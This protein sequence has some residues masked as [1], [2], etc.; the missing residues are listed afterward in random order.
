MLPRFDY[1]IN[2]KNTM[3]SPSCISHSRI[4][5]NYLFIIAIVFFLHFP[6]LENRDF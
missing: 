2:K 4:L 5:Y 1:S 6:L 3:Y